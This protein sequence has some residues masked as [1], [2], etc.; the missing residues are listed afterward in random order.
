MELFNGKREISINE[1]ETA[2]TVSASRISNKQEKAAQ[3]AQDAQREYGGERKQKK[4][5][6]KGV[7]FAEHGSPEAGRDAM[8]EGGSDNKASI[9]YLDNILDANQAQKNGDDDAL[10][11]N[12]MDIGDLSKSKSRIERN[13]EHEKE[14]ME[15]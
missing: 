5:D 3:L 6:G 13:D 9:K 8:R 10:L 7:S 2:S 15:E 4:L 11:E 1:G 14:L 12:I